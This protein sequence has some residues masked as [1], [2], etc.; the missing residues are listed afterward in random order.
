[1]KRYLN[2]PE[3]L[4]IALKLGK[5]VKHEDISISFKLVEGLLCAYE[6]GICVEVNVTIPWDPKSF[7]VEERFSFKGFKF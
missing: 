5:V 6:N 2:S 1:M 3:Q 4:V 7:Y